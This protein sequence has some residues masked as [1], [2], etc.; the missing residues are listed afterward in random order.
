ME[1][2]QDA[3][4]ELTYEPPAIEAVDDVEG[5]LGSKTS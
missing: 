3:T 4:P 5:L 1:A 2:P